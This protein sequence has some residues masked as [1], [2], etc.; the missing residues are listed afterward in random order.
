MLL[1]REVKTSLLK[2]ISRSLHFHRCKGSQ[3][4]R[5]AEKQSL[6]FQLPPAPGQ[7]G[8][9][10]LQLTTLGDCWSSH[11]VGTAALVP[12]RLSDV[13]CATPVLGRWG[14]PWLCASKPA[15]NPDHGAHPAFS[16]LRQPQQTHALP[17]TRGIDCNIVRIRA[18][19]YWKSKKGRSWHQTDLC[20]INV[21]ASDRGTTQI[22]KGNVC[23]CAPRPSWERV[24]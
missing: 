10:N 5:F 19:L 20:Q 22:S 16:L 21:P 23:N 17:G 12:W 7:T 13:L 6:E 15:A 9:I 3:Q 18:L 4:L 14:T 24:S 2:L 8:I 11:S 1:C